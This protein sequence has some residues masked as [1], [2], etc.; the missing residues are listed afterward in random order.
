VLREI[1][2]ECAGVGVPLGIS[3]E[4]VSIFK[5]EI[6]G[7]HELFRRLQTIL[8]DSRG[9]PWKVQ[10]LEVMPPAGRIDDDDDALVAFDPSEKV[11]TLLFGVM[12]GAATVSLGVILGGKSKHA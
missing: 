1:L 5:S 12:V 9:S 11:R 4:S 6:D 7:V 8:L 10:W 2:S 3:C